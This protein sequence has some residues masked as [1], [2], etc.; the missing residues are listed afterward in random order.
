M[1]RTQ[2]DSP[3]NAGRRCSTGDHGICGE[4]TRRW[5]GGHDSPRCRRPGSPCCRR[6]DWQGPRLR[7][8]PGGTSPVDVSDGTLV[9]DVVAGRG[10]HWQREIDQT[11]A[12]VIEILPAEEGLVL[13]NE[14]PV[15]AYLT[16]VISAEMSGACPEAFLRAQC[17]VARSWLLA[18]TEDK[19]DA[20]P[21]D[22]CN[23]DCCQRYQGLADVNPTV[24]R[25]CRVRGGQVLLN[26]GGEILGREL[27]QVLRRRQ[28]N[29]RAVWGIDKPGLE[30][31]VD[32]PAGDA[33]HRFYPLA[34]ADVDE[35]LDGAWVG[36]T[37]AWCSP[38]VISRA[39]LERFLGRGGRDRRLLPLDG[40]LRTGGA[41]DAA[42]REDRRTPWNPAVAGFAR[43]RTWSGRTR[44][45]HGV[46][47]DR[48]VRSGAGDGIGH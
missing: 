48:P 30:P 47:L 15:E 26:P 38:N 22:R 44:Q 13:V 19:H 29:A 6:T 42:R 1:R 4:E 40:A 8:E 18:M 9:R 11:L 46:G 31:I 3:E 2:R 41:G 16:G 17:V 23:D 35:Y 14:L 39:D 37:Q 24:R 5:R 34:E 28:R 21:F 32:A 12:G 25:Q 45:P 27:R 10:F 36:K 43:Y 7:L 33:A 20:D